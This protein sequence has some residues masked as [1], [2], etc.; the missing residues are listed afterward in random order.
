MPCPLQASLFGS[1]RVRAT[2]ERRERERERE[3][4]RQRED[5]ASDGDVEKGEGHSCGRPLSSEC[6]THTLALALGEKS[7]KR[8]QLF[9]FHSELTLAKHARA[10][11]VTGSL[12]D[13]GSGDGNLSGLQWPSLVDSA[14]SPV[15]SSVRRPLS[16]NLLD[17]KVYEL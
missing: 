1:R 14:G 2:R 10:V 15:S 13:F 3:T 7:L 9:P 8:F 16:L 12:G 17:T 4:E 11:V 5:G 6:G